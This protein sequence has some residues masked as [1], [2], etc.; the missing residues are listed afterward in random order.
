MAWM[1]LAHALAWFNTRVILVLIFYS[2]ITPI[3]LIMRLFG[4]DSL[5][6]KIEKD[7]KSYWKEKSKRE[8][9]QLNYERQF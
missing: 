9:N 3:G 7:N 5:D 8:S 2:L 1:K 4:L 6:K